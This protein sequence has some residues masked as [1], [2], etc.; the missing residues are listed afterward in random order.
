M[1]G[2]R[3]D[4]IVLGSGLEELVAA[5]SLAGE[6]R[7]V[8]VLEAGPSIGG[9]A[10]AEELLPGF[11]VDPVH[12][13]AGFLDPRVL[14][15]LELDRH[16]LALLA[17]DPV[18]AAPAERGSALTFWREP[19]RTRASIAGRSERD[20][21][22]WEAFAERMEAFARILEE[23]AAGPAPRPAGPLRELAPF[24]GLGRRVRKLGRDDMTEL[25]RV[26][27]L[28][29]YDL[30]EDSFE[31]ELLKG[32]LGALSVRGLFHG[33]RAQ[34]TA[35]VLLHHLVGS[36][37]G[38]FGIRTVVRGG[39]GAL[40]EALVAAARARGVELRADSR[41][42]GIDIERGRATAVRLAD[43]AELTA[44]AILSGLGPARTLLDLAGPTW[45]DPDFVH[46]LRQIRFRGG[47]CRIHLA[48]SEAPHF[49]GLAD[50]PAG[51][52]VVA[53]RLDD[54][55]RAFDDAKHGAASERPVLEARIPS[56]ADPTLAPAG[57]HV[58]SIDARFVPVDGRAATEPVAPGGVSAETLAHRAVAILA[59]RAPNLPGAI[60]ERRILL[61]TDIE[62]RYGLDGGDP[63]QGELALDQLL[64]MRPVPGW[65]GYRTPIPGLYLCGSGTHPAG[66]IT[67]VS[68]RLA[69]DAVVMDLEEQR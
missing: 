2:A 27:P 5:A 9:T 42:E 36:P 14:R 6:G 60:L 44:R 28:P 48:L 22:R 45:L 24:L 21:G 49:E 63:F 39:V 13:D 34:G 30:L 61:P 12:A 15:G 23:V 3:Y 57:R 11:R 32:A 55:E 18:L 53:A 41:V 54:V 8:L 20:A 31:D 1:S 25:F 26:L 33:P 40:A 43:G 37:T 69:A 65:S 50:P 67:G 46:A 51:V 56:L 59:E 29:A 17:P 10:A 16:G 38:C 4:A 64:F 52:V 66:A 62:A 19:A 58:M 7:S 68:G 47:F 35:L